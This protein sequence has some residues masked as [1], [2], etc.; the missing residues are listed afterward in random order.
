MKQLLCL[1]L[2]STSLALAVP[3]LGG[4]EVFL[5][6]SDQRQ[7]RDGEWLELTLRGY[8]H[9]LGL[10]TE[11]LPVVRMGF[12]DEDGK[13]EYFQQIGLSKDH[14]PAV[15]LVK[16][17]SQ[18]KE[19][20]QSVVEGFVLT[21]AQREK[22]LDAPRQ[23]FIDW[24]R[25]SGRENLVSLILP[26]PPPA[27]EPVELPDPATI[28]F[29]EQRYD[30]AI[31]LARESADRVLEER[32]KQ[33][34]QE[35]AAL[36]FVEER[37]A[38]ALSVYSRLLELYPEESLF[39]SKVEE[40]STKTE[41]LLIGAWTLRSSSG[42]IEF[43]AFED[44]TLK[45]KGALFLIPFPGKMEGHWLLTGDTERTFQL[46][47]KNGALHNIKVHEHGSSFEGRG[48]SDGAVSGERAAS[49]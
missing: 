9:E 48:L 49:P 27:A 41:D 45:G 24:L 26:P 34:Y 30:D 14:L 6:V 42:W 38:L 7:D 31:L 11:D 10:K 23:L 33:R 35:Q 2:L 44:G 28:A 13:K 1:F 46:H 8:R 37:Q 39:R 36:A 4:K 20:P 18:E 15:C 47:W 19:G 16:W 3:D 25:R 32:A 29:Q 17:H 40:L 5:V 43:E 22:G 12:G 21:S